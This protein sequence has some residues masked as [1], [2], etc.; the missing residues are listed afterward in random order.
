MQDSSQLNKLNGDRIIKIE[1]SK[2]W[3][4]ELPDD[5]EK[6]PLETALNI[7]IQLVRLHKK[8][9]RYQNISK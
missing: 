3:R 7:F 8:N 2:D 9:K 6:R 5:I 1:K 4:I